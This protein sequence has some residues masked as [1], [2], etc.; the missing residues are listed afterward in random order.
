MAHSS[1]LVIPTTLIEYEMHHQ[2]SHI[3]NETCGAHKLLWGDGKWFVGAHTGEHQNAKIS[4]A[5]CIPRTLNI[6]HPDKYHFMWSLIESSGASGFECDESVV[7]ARAAHRQPVKNSNERWTEKVNKRKVKYQQRVLGLI[8]S[9][10][11]R[12]TQDVDG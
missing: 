2:G 4:T 8:S 10:F 3:N 11:A 5:V 6:I 1:A 9:T 7:G 12:R